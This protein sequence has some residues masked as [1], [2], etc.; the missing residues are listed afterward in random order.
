MPKCRERQPRVSS[1]QSVEKNDAERGKS[2][3]FTDMIVKYVLV[4][5]LSDAEISREVLSNKTRALYQM[6]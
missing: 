3:D 1:E 4:N 5:C 2:V 6:L